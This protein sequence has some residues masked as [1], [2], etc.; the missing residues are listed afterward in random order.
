VSDYAF[1]ASIGLLKRIPS[2]TVRLGSRFH[3]RE[4]PP[5]FLQIQEFEIAHIPVTVNQ[6]AVFLDSAAVSEPRWWS[7]AGWDWLQGK[8]DGWGREDRRKPDRW[9]IQR[10]R[11]HHPVVGITWFEAEA[12]CNWVGHQKKLVVRLPGEEEW[13]RA[14]R[15]DDPRPFPWGEEFDA[16]LA[17]TLESDHRDTV[18]V[19]SIPG[20]S[21]PFGVLG[22]CGNI[23]EWTASKYEPAPDEIFPSS[24]LRVVRGGSY[25]D[26]AFGART[27]YRRAY[28]PGYFYPFLGFRVVV[29]SR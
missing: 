22:M 27:S 17:N 6:Y 21:S 10:R 26:T 3:P 2:G 23:Q 19:A 15:G 25:D 20:D 12:Y 16:A 7:A 18:E 5:R 4:Q 29:G 14:A 28:P 8:S 9:Q 24:D 1:K 11:Q 13:E